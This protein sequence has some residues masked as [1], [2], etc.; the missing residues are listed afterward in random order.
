MEKALTGKQAQMFTC[1]SDYARKHHFPPSVQDIA[2]AA[3]ITDGAAY[4]VLLAL[5]RKGYVMWSGGT[6]RTIQ[7]VPHVIVDGRVYVRIA[8]GGM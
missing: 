4:K 7:L 3:G 2:Q 1:I 6:G 5:R 8:G